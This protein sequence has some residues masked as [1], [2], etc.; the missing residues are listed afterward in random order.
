MLPE[1]Y[2]L[3]RRQRF[4]YIFQHGQRLAAARLVIHWA[5]I[6]EQE[7]Q[8]PQWGVIVSKKVSPLAVVRNRVKRQLRAALRLLLPSLEPGY[9][10]VLVARQSITKAAWTEI[11]TEVASLMEMAGVLKNPDPIKPGLPEASPPQS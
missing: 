1:P 7:S 11:A 4:A 2:R 8:L 6:P 5:K 10:G 3:R 9:W